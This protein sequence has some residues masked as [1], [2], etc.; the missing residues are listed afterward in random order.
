MFV[1]DFDMK[2]LLFQMQRNSEGSG[3]LQR[4]RRN[5]ASA[6]ISV[7]QQDL[8]KTVFSFEFKKKKK[9]SWIFSRIYSLAN[10]NFKGKYPF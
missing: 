9:V 2:M 4:Y 1:L 8:T 7:P 5:K 6:V 3:L 10:C